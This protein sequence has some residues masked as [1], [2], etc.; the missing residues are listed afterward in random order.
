MWF[1][2]EPALLAQRDVVGAIFHFIKH[3]GLV[4][5]AGAIIYFIGAVHVSCVAMHL[6]NMRCEC[7]FLGATLLEKRFWC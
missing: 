3:W 6:E 1:H 7:K 4:K 5:H 2:G